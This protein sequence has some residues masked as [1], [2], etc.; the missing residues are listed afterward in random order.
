MTSVILIKKLLSI[1]ELNKD[2][3]TQLVLHS[4]NSENVLLMLIGEFQFPE[5]LPFSKNDNYGKSNTIL[6]LG[7]FDPY[8]RPADAV[9]FSYE[10]DE[11]MWFMSQE[12][13]D[14]YLAGDK[15]IV[16]RSYSGDKFVAKAVVST[17]TSSSSMSVESWQK[18]HFASEQ[19][20]GLQEFAS[21]EN[22]IFL[23]SK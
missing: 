7:S 11:C 18:Q 4:D 10:Q 20:I 12:D 21:N 2:V 14:A 6:T 8:A 15:N 17:R 16:H 9:K 13:A 1:S 23:K 22:G 3:L 5:L 19:P